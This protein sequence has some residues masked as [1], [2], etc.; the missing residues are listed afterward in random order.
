MTTKAK[1]SLDTIRV[2]VGKKMGGIWKTLKKLYSAICRPTMDYGCQ[3]YNTA[4]A[5]RLMKL[6][7]IHKEGIRM[8][9]GAIR[10]SPVES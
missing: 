6:D 7:S 8:Y 10:T 3:L 5:G 1:R 9:V 4:S 2:E